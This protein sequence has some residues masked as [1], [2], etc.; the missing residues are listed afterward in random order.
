[1]TAPHTNLTLPTFEADRIRDTERRRLRALVAGDMEVARQLHA[2]DF[3]LITPIGDALSRDEYLGA[4][5]TGYLKYLVWEPEAIEVRL[6]GN[7]AAIRYQ[8]QLE[9]IFGEHKVPISRYWHTD[10]YE[11]H[12]GC[13][14]AV[15]SQATA[16]KGQQ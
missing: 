4:I 15:W 11:L 5:A 3:Q 12:D 8:A 6:Y 7:A 2:P 16:I 10:T 9:V 13:W 1:M 14:L